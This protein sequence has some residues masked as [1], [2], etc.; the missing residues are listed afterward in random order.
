MIDV[1]DLPAR[2]SLFKQLLEG[3]ETDGIDYDELAN[4][5]AGYSGSDINLVCR[6]AA[7]RPL[8]KLFDQ[9]DSHIPDENVDEQHTFKTCPISQKDLLDSIRCTKSS[10]DDGLR[11]KYDEWQQSFGS[12]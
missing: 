6:E 9:L 1:P 11:K 5:T 12:V 8:R 4:L 7:M 3:S 2:K 10:S